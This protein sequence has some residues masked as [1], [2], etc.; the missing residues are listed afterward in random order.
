MV[1]RKKYLWRHAKGRW[2]VRIKSKLQR[3]GTA[4]GTADLDRERWQIM[5]G[6]RVQAKTSWAALIDDSRSSDRWTA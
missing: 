2:Y 5:N 1:T 6:K 4:E 3:I